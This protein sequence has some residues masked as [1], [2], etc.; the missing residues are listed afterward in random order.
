MTGRNR[1]GRGGQY[2]DGRR[3]GKGFLAGGNGCVSEGSMCYYMAR[4]RGWVRA[5]TGSVTSGLTPWTSSGRMRHAAPAAK[6]RPLLR[7]I[8]AVPSLEQK[9]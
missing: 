3:D 8:S 5:S 6:T 7:G 9:Q 4:P 2:L 1:R